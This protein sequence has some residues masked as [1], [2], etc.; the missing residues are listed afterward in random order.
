[1]DIM[2]IL[3]W[4]Q[5]HSILWMFVVFLLIVAVTFWPGRRRTFDQIS[6]IP[7]EDDR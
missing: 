5:H 7:L 1:M 4:M 6:R 3:L 2:P